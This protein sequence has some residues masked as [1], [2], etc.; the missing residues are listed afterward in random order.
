MDAACRRWDQSLGDRV[1]VDTM[2]YAVFQGQCN[3]FPDEVQAHPNAV[4]PPSTSLWASKLSNTSS[5]LCLR[6]EIYSRSF[7]RPSSTTSPCP[8]HSFTSP[9]PA[10]LS[11]Q[12]SKL[13]RY[14]LRSSNTA[15]PCPS[16]VSAVNKIF[17]EGRKSEMESV[18]WPGV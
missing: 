8:Q 13:A 14:A 1:V 18:V 16:T 2:G 9:S 11:T 7:L 4:T 12:A 15:V 17:W 10:S 3:S 6:C 5:S